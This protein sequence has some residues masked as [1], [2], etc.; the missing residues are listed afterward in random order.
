MLHRNRALFGLGPL[1][2]VNPPP[3]GAPAGDPAPP[4]TGTP[5]APAA[6]T[7]PVQDPDRS[8]WIPRERFDDV[9]RKL[10]DLTAAEQKRTEDEAK[11]RGDFEALAAGEKTKR[12]EAEA[13]AAR[14][15]RRAAFIAK[16]SGKVQDPDAAYKLAA[17]DG[18]L[19]D[20][21]V[22]DEDDAKDPKAVEKIVDELVKRYEF[23]KSTDKSRSFGDAAGGQN[24]API[25]TSKMTGSDMLRAGY[26]SPPTRR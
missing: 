7:P 15:A 11:K 13:R 12:E 25:D 16:A 18:M 10:A 6:G 4:A 3:G 22:D 23:L 14:V 24:G 1:H 21:E 26:S 5:S 19:N 8:G 17:A 2:E 9:N 20:L